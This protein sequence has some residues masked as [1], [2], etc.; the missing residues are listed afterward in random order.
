MAPPP[1]KSKYGVKNKALDHVKSNGGSKATSAA[2][3]RASSVLSNHSSAAVTS[4]TKTK[5]KGKR[6]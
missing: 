3:S 6:K 2:P 4:K 1:K 5:L